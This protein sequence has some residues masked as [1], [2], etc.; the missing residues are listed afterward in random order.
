MLPHR[1]RSTS[2]SASQD[3]VRLWTRLLEREVRK[4]SGK[5][6][7]CL[8][9]P[10]SRLPR[11]CHRR[12]LRTALGPRHRDWINP[13]SHW[14]VSSIC[15]RG[16]APGRFR[17]R[18]KEV[19]KYLK[20]KSVNKA[21]RLKDLEEGSRHWVEWLAVADIHGYQTASRYAEDDDQSAIVSKERHRGYHGSCD[22]EAPSATHPDGSQTVECYQAAVVW[23]FT[24]MPNFDDFSGLFRFLHATAE[25]LHVWCGQKAEEQRAEHV[26]TQR[27]SA[28]GRGG[29]QLPLIDEFLAVFMRS[30]LGLLL[31]DIC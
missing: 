26:A 10:P 12:L 1:A 19:Q 20:K 15:I 8:L 4:L 17:T 25:H 27:R 31:E 22:K 9:P 28:Q 14:K 23:F 5:G 6:G 3:E 7:C 30:H 21:K 2:N 18:W 11:T 16:T 24:G 29:R 13:L